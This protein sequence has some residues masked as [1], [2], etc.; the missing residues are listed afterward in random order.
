ML[1]ITPP[2]RSILEVPLLEVPPHIGALSAWYTDES[3]HVEEGLPPWPIL[4]STY[5]V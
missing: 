1:T 3:F 4:H 2:K 5:R